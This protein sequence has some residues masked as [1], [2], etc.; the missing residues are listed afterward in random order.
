MNETA[1][2][3]VGNAATEVKYR[4]TTSGIPMA[5]FRLA[6]T[7]RRWDRERS[8]WVDA[9]AS[10][11]T[12]R[13][14]RALAGNVA[15]SV[16]RGDPLVVQGRMRVHEWEK[17]GQRY[18]SVQVD[19]GAVGHDLAR[20]TSAFRRGVR[21]QPQVGPVAEVGPGPEGRADPGGAPPPEAV[22]EAAGGQAAGDGAEDAGQAAG[23]RAPEPVGAD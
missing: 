2:T 19:A 11:Y 13:A 17:D 21:A 3:L 6:T 12:V 14:W 10:F 16:G 4:E 1:I 8:C 5:S 15:T 18:T 9:G 20:G 7:E 23:R 22:G